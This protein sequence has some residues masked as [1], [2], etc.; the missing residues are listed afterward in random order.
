M[1]SESTVENNAENDEKIKKSEEQ[2]PSTQ[3]S[4]EV[5]S[6][7]QKTENFCQAYFSGDIEGVKEF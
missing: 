5:Q 6:L 4:E 3:V 1:K 7:Q 2:I